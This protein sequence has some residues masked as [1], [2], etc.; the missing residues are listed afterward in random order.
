MVCLLGSKYFLL[1][2][3]INF[4]RT[5]GFLSWQLTKHKICFCH[6]FTFYILIRD[7]ETT[8]YQFMS[9]TLLICRSNFLRK[10]GVPFVMKLFSVFYTCIT[11][12]QATWNRHRS[13]LQQ[14]CS[15]YLLLTHSNITVTCSFNFL[16]GI[17]VTFTVN[18]KSIVFFCYN[19]I[20]TLPNH[21]HIHLTQ[22]L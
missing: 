18:K 8:L 15:S 1:V 17:T 7:V 14:N 22:T 6:I 21:P 4:L 10:T 16:S 9:G 3:I 19:S 2:A 5:S 12:L 11:R 20:T 13:Y